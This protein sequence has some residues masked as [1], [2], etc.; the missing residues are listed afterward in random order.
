MHHVLVIQATDAD[1]LNGSIVW[2]EIVT[3][4]VPYLVDRDTGIVTTAGLFT[5]LSGTNN[6]IMVRAFDNFGLVP[7]FTTNDILNVSFT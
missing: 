4:Q 1:T 6:Q 7:T 3:P 2:F 5:G